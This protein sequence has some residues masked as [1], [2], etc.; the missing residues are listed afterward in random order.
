MDSLHPFVERYKIHSNKEERLCCDI[1]VII[2]CYIASY[3][4]NAISYWF[5]YN[6]RLHHIIN[7]YMDLILEIT[8]KGLRI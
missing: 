4:H 8:V 6:L 7:E 3:V 5:S 1:C 2:L